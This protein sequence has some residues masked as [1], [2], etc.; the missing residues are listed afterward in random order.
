MRSGNS[1][2]SIHPQLPAPRDQLLRT[3]RRGYVPSASPE[4]F[5]APGVDV[6]DAAG[7]RDRNCGV[8]ARH[9]DAGTR[10]R[11]R[12]AP[13]APDED[14]ALLLRVFARTVGRADSSSTE[15]W[16]G[17]WDPGHS[18]PGRA[19]ATRGPDTP[20]RRLVC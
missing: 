14:L 3:L 20:A 19:A 17:H 7:C 11:F 1:G 8:R 5:P 15:T 10:A 6:E 4:E 13:R 18:P 2:K 9:R 16:M 12:H